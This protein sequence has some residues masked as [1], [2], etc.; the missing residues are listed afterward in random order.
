M[1]DR[2]IG[3]TL[4]CFVRKNGKYLMLHRT[5]NKRI[6]PDVWMAPGGHREIGEGLFECAIR[7]I[8]EETGLKINN[9]K[10]RA[11][12][13]AVLQDVSQELYIHL[14]TADY[15]GGELKLD[16]EDGELVWLTPEE[17]IKLPHLLA[18][19][20]EVLPHVFSDTDEVIS[21]IAVYNKGNN[22]TKFILEM[23]G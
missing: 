7:E 9:L 5:R 19:L 2:K 6:M 22:M 4:E 3:V 10:I 21:Y 13:V 8:F 11:S 14:L 15:A 18:E 16:S 17:I 20:R 12:G 23:A 1:T